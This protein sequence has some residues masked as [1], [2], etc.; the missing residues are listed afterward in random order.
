MQD[1]RWTLVAEI[2]EQEAFAPVR[3]LQARLLTVGLGVSA[4]F[5]AVASWLGA[6]V[7]RP[8]LELARTVARLGAGDRGA[9]VPVRSR[10]EVGQLAEAFNR[11]SGDL[12]R[13]TVSKGELERLAG[14]LI[15]AQ[16]DERRRVAREL[17]DDLVQRVA[18]TAIE[19]GRLERMAATAPA[20]VVP[21]LEQLK[22]TLAQ[23][24]E[25]VH[26][27]SRRIHP[28]MLDELGLTAAIEAE[29]RAFMERGGPPVDVR[30]TG[31]HGSVDE[32]PR[33]AT[34]A[35][36]RLVQE[37]LRNAWQHAA[38]TEVGIDLMRSD[39]V[40]RLTVRDNGHGFDRTAPDWKPGLGLASMEERTR[41]LGGHM[42]IASA[43]GQ[44]TRIEVTLPIGG[45]EER[46]TDA[47]AED[48]A[49]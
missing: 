37:A 47:K 33:D 39:G 36:Y 34:L 42:S 17:H 20:A 21:G 8:V 9:T 30:L 46:T 19:V 25:D 41:L 49:R 28:A 10:D 12:E 27:L 44:G 23:L 6:S 48:P 5:F 13:T 43:P 7:T 29:C 3:S 11:M 14:R 35:L 18:A 4:L 15:S 45:H 24:S 26:R 2:A 22:R 16:E 1:L 31:E 40:V 32:L 38:A